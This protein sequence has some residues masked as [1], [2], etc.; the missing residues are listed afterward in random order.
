MSTTERRK[1]YTHEQKEAERQ[2]RIRYQAENREKLARKSAERRAAGKCKG[3]SYYRSLQTPEK[4]E[5]ELA[6][7]RRRYRENRE[8]AL[9]YAAEYR[10]K[11]YERLK[12]EW[13]GAYGKRKDYFDKYREKNK[14]LIAARRSAWTVANR[15]RIAAKNAEWLQNNLDK[16]RTHQHNRRAKKKANGGILSPDIVEKLMSLQRGKCACCRRVL[17]DDYDIDHIVPIALGGVNSD[18]NVQLLCV[19]CNRSKGAKRP[20]DFMQSRGML[21]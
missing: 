5:E 7:K 20:E 17:R 13:T 14:D 11:N 6:Q 8:A 21:L 10:E 1:N 12:A 15:E 19:R 18:R 9:A 3:T 4:R 16:H 2:Y